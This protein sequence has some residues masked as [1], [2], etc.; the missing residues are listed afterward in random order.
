MYDS[1]QGPRVIISTE[2]ESRRVGAR[3]WGKGNEELELNG[4]RVSVWED[5]IILEMDGGDGCTMA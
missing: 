4:G 3:G 2:T 5:E 1:I